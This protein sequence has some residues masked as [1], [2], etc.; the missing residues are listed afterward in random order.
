MKD[1]LIK[2]EEKHVRKVKRWYFNLMI[3]ANFFAMALIIIGIVWTLR[4]YRTVEFKGDSF[5]ILNKTVRQ[6]GTLIY[7]SD[8]CKYGNYS[9][10]TTRSFINGIIYTMPPVTTNRSLGCH[11]INVF[12]KIPPDLPVGENYYINMLYKFKVNP[13]R[14]IVVEHRSEKFSIIES[15]QF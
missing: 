14:D 7:T 8:Y 6:G 1:T 5:K 12:V 13:I 9:S 15:T 2:I 4:P 11:K 10:E 3:L